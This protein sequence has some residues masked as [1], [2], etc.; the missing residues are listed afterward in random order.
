M[1]AAS[2]P[3]RPYLARDERRRLLLDTAAKLVEKEGWDK[4]NMSALAQRSNTSRQLLYQHF[5]SLEDLM[6]ATGTHIFQQVY[7]GTRDAIEQR[8]DDIVATLS[9]AQ[10]ITLDLPKGRAQALWQIIAAAFPVDHEL[11]RFGRRMRHLITRLWQPAVAE[12]FDLDEQAA[13]ATTWM[14]M[15]AFW[16]GY[17][18]VEDGELTK[19]QAIDRL[20]WIVSSMLA[21]QKKR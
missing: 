4:L 19:Q 8:S 3:K 12:A 13:S 14:M 2:T 1:T 15:M 7:T 17:R 20:N 9:Q 11:T 18:L 21:G 16:G 6:V 5:D 10:Q